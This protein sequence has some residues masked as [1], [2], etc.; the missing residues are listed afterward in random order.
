MATISTL[1]LAGTG[2]S[3]RTFAPAP[4]IASVEIDFA[5]ALTAKGS[6]L[7]AA[8]V[9]EAINIPAGSVVLAAGIQTLVADDAT[10]LTLDLGTAGDADGW[11]DGYDQAAAAAL[12]YATSIIPNTT[13]TEQ[14]HADADTID[15]TLATLTGTLTE[16]KIR[17]WAY[18]ADIS[19]AVKQPGIVQIG[20]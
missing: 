6:A 14:F 3:F 8:D 13:A 18:I 5:D 20:S 17:V 19:Y 4:Y 12:D 16:G 7:A 2:H 1:D 10:T 11:V 15:V 9:I